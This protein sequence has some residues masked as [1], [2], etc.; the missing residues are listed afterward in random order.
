MTSNTHMLSGSGNFIQ[1]GGRHQV[2]GTLSVTGGSQPAYGLSGG[3][4]IAPTIEI[5]YGTFS[6]MAG[7]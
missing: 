7:R 2:S 1:T 4:V 3:E 5:T 6:T